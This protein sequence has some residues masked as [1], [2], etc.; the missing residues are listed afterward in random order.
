[1]SKL[2]DP[3][4]ARFPLMLLA[5]LILLTTG[6]VKNEFTVEFSAPK[7]V[8]A[9]FEVFYYASDKRT[10]VWLEAAAP[11]QDGRFE[12]K[13]IT[14]NPTLVYIT[15][16]ASG[17]VEVVLYVERGDKMVLSG[18]TSS[19]LEWKL[20]KGNKISNH[21][22]DWR[23]ANVNT[24]RGGNADSINAA[25]RREVKANPDL[26]SS[27]IILATYY[28]RARNPGEFAT[29]WNSLDA[30][31]RTPALT[32]LL[33]LPDLASDNAYIP[34]SEDNIRRAGIN[35]RLR[36][37][38]IHTPGGRRVQVRT[39][40]YPASIFYFN[41][42]GTTEHHTNLDTLRSLLRSWPDSTSRLIADISLEA[43]SL[44]WIYPLRSDSLHKVVHGWM[45]LGETDTRL[46]RLGVAR[47][48]W[49][50]VTDSTG[51]Q[52]YAG[53]SAPKASETFR[54][55]MRGE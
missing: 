21:I 8:W 33:G 43:D 16:R 46:R 20:D 6:C 54:K 11:L 53:P 3:H 45:P 50:I 30:D 41:R 12:L 27:V 25:V 36:S 37:M 48:P 23:L 10:G 19:I 32:D 40:D 15:S 1:M 18:T 4:P 49:W 38:V 26:K 42:A 34:L 5:L 47:A 7:D 55:A 52:L 2:S 28:D 39:G 29:L 13:G 14:R 44:S 31:A 35:T 17:P 24:L 51:H 22:S 9:N